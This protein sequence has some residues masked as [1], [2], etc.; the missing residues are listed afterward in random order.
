MAE[1]LCPKC[2]RVFA[3]EL[4]GSQRYCKRC[5]QTYKKTRAEAKRLEA[6]YK[7]YPNLRPQ[8]PAPST[9]S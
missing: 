8:L 7:L 5:W 4:Y 1:K 6:I 3:V 9:E 2:H